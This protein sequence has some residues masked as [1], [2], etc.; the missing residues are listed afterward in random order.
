MATFGTSCDSEISAS[1]YYITDLSS[2]KYIDLLFVNFNFDLK[3]VSYFVLFCVEKSE[4]KLTI[5]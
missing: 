4:L 3:I 2:S 5:N 1:L